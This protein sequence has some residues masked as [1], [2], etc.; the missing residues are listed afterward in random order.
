[1]LNT[2]PAPAYG[3]MSDSKDQIQGFVVLFAVLDFAI[4]PSKPLGVL[5]LIKVPLVIVGNIL[6]YLF[7]C[8]FLVGKI[9][10]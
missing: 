10:M 3:Y 7:V 9:T 5:F 6:S 1:M 8:L 4:Y 2:C